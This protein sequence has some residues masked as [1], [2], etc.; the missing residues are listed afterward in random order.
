[1][2]IEHFKDC[3]ERQNVPWNKGNLTGAIAEQVEV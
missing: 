3:A 2:D 1:M